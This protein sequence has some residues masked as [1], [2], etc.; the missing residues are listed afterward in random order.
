MKDLQ[1]LFTPPEWDG[2]HPLAR[3]VFV[4]VFVGLMIPVYWIAGLA[5]S[6]VVALLDRVLG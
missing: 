4:A 1:R 5:G 3:L 6:T 2:W